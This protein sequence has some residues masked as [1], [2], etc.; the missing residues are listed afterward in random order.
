MVDGMANIERTERMDDPHRA[1]WYDLVTGLSPEQRSTLMEGLNRRGQL[2]YENGRAAA[3]QGA[4]GALRAARELLHE[5]VHD[6][7]IDGAWLS[8]AEAWLNRNGER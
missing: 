2:A 4:V 3:D 6:S 8:D 5:A 1:A 7:G